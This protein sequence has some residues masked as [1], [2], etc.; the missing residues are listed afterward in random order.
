MQN[1]TMACVVYINEQTKVF[2]TEFASTLG[3]ITAAS[4]STALLLPLYNYYRTRYLKSK[5]E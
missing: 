4:L 1:E 2:M 3:Q 5:S